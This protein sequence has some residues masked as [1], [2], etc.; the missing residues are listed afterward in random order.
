MK[1][2]RVAFLGAGEISERFIKMSKELK[3][4]E[5]CA[6]FS[7]NIKNAKAR[8]QQYGI[9]NYYD[10][11]K[12]MLKTEK[13]DAVVVTS[14]H[15]LHM[16]HTIDC[17]NAKAH[18]LCEKPMATDLKEAQAMVK[19]SKK[20]RKLLMVLP[21]DHYP[22]YIASFEYIQEK[23]IGQIT[24]A[25][26]ELS[27]PGPPRNNWYYDKK[28]AKGGAML[29]VGCYALSRLISIM[30]PVKKISAFSNVLLR[31]RIL[32][33]GTKITPTVDDNNVMILE[34][35][36]GVFATAKASWCH[37][38][39]ENKT[40]IY[41]RKGAVYIN[42]DNVDGFPIVIQTKNKNVGEK[43]KY[44]NLPDCYKPAKMPPWGPEY[45]IMGKF[46]GYIVNKQKPVY[47]AD[48]SLHIMEVMHKAYVAA[49]TGKTQK[50][51][52]NF[53]VWWKK[54]KTIQKYNKFI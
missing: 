33:D 15:S 45:D 40:V 16:R 38:Y 54:E 31:K 26:S 27:F 41:G 14:P 9:P 43:V 3:N 11:Y 36:G 19:A 7:R 23:Y 13:P 39:V 29:D 46:I 42:F 28:I 35:A 34:F 6:I 8:A 48:Q 24:S 49:K 52:S 20:N 51:V 21:F 32:E 30:G 18:V 47:D 53:R 4:V 1:M 25:H 22:H 44:R 37:T 50:I 10:D 5:L 17:L 2:I 12:L